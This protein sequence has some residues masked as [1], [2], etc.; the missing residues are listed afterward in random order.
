MAPKERSITPS[1]VKDES[2]ASPSVLLDTLLIPES[3]GLL[4]DDIT[5]GGACDR[6]GPACG[7]GCEFKERLCYFF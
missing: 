4:P 2:S 1:E 5:G 6:A 7:S 3:T